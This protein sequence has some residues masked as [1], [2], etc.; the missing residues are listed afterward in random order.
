MRDKRV[1]AIVGREILETTI[2]IKAI[3]T[4]II[5]LSQWVR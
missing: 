3:G 2:G 5:A 1:L 4:I